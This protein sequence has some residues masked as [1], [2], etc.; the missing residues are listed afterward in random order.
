M[1]LAPGLVTFVILF[2]LFAFGGELCAQGWQ[3]GRGNTGGGMDAWPVAT[4]H[5][6]N[7]FV[8]GANFSGKLI[9]TSGSG[10]GINAV[11]GSVSVP[12][13]KVLPKNE[14]T[15]FDQKQDWVQID[16]HKMIDEVPEVK[17][18]RQILD[19]RE[20]EIKRL[21]SEAVPTKEISKRISLAIKIGEMDEPL[22]DYNK[23]LLH[24]LNYNPKEDKKRE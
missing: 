8:A 3:W 6:G 11:F 13:S 23:K 1:K 9:S 18:A 24:A 14:D 19:W 22:S 2:S 15:L 21:K 5:S 16:F 20:K 7:V 10:Y 12:F 4:D 17:T